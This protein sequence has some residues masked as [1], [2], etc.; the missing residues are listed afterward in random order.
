M[1][2]RLYYMDHVEE[3]GHRDWSKNKIKIAN[4]VEDEDVKKII[5]DSDPSPS[6][7]VG[8]FFKKISQTND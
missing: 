4:K 2:D 7:D 8:R 6:Y 5:L 3:Q 1:V